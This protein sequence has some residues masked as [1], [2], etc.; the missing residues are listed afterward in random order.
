[1]DAAGGKIKTAEASCAS[2]SA[3]YPVMEGVAL[4]LTPELPRKD[5]WEQLES[6]LGRQ[7]RAH[8]E[9]ERKLMKVPV[10]T[11]TPADQFLRGLLLEERGEHEQAAQV[12]GQASRGLYTP[13]YLACA[14]SMIGHLIGQLAGVDEPVF[15]LASGRG[16]LVEEMLRRLKSPVVATDFSPR[17][18]RGDLRRW[19]WLGMHDRVSLLSFDARRTPFDD[20]A[21]KTMTSYLGLPNIEEPGHLLHEL[22]RVVSG[23][24]IAVMHFF[25]EDDEANREAILQAELQTMLYRRTALAAFLAAGFDVE[26]ACVCMSRACPT[27]RSIVL[28]GVG[29]DALPV[30]ETTLEWCVLVAQ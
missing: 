4:L 28:D 30:A 19:Q 25:P 17:V 18:L 9:V 22:R 16:R 20:G 1:V 5:M 13:E 8:P 7:V 26:V 11:L 6:Q 23:K 21:V 10:N 15:D 24:L 3:S 12:I 2:C 14:D 29:I 27:P